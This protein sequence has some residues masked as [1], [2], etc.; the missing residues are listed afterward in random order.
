M[1][2]LSLAPVTGFLPCRLLKMQRASRRSAAALDGVDGSKP[3]GESP[4]FDVRTS[5]ASEGMSS[6]GE[7]AADGNCQSR[8]QTGKAARDRQLTQIGKNL[9]VS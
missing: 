2:A 7:M 9:V 1:N 6:P 4:S 5:I 8:C 3:G